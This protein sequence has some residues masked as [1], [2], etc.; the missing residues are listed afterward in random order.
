MN[1]ERAIERIVADHHAR[2]ELL[3]L[4]AKEKG[5]HALALDLERVDPDLVA[6]LRRAGFDVDERHG[7]SARAR[8]ERFGQ[9]W[10][11]CHARHLASFGDR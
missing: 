10:D 11:R 8:S 5:D 1:L 4:R 7:E 3:W 2:R 9:L 6:R